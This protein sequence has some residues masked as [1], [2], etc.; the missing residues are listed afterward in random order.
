[1]ASVF[2]P[3]ESRVSAP[4]PVYRPVALPE[5]W[6]V[7]EAD[8]LWVRVLLEY[9]AMGSVAPCLERLY[10]NFR[11]GAVTVV[12]NAA[13]V[14]AKFP[15]GV[16]QNDFSSETMERIPQGYPRIVGG[17]FFVNAQERQEW[18]FNQDNGYHPVVRK[19]AIQ[20][21]PALAQVQ[22]PSVAAEIAEVTKQLRPVLCKGVGFAGI[23][24]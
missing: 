12:V 15:G 22:S 9:R 3:S 18:Y 6:Y 10:E 21:R 17:L 23:R 8:P 7:S 19:V 13:E 14:H 16:D 4:G 20:N 5:G 24:K 2:N 11:R 1:M